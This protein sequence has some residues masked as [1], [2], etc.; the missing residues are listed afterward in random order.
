M[1]LYL[2]RPFLQQVRELLDRN[3]SVAEIANRLGVGS[4]IINQSLQIIRP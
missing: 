3:L 1:P 4:Q 2:Q